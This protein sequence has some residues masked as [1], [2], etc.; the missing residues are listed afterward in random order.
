M[1]IWNAIF[2]VVFGR[3]ST[4]APPSNQRSRPPVSGAPPPLAPPTRPTTQA[5]PPAAG[6]PAPTPENAPAPAP[7]PASA[8]GASQANDGRLSASFTLAEFCESDTATRLGIDNSPP[9]EIVERL[10]VT[11]MRMEKVRGALG[12][13]LFRSSH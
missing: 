6:T 7:L 13:P 1:G 4:S 10:R 8:P 12:A 5:R 3:R 9:P 11:A 2:R